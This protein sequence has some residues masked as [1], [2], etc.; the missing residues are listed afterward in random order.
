M[1][2]SISGTPTRDPAGRDR[3]AR[4]EHQEPFAR[5]SR[6]W[7]L[8]EALGYAG[9]FIDPTGVLASQRF[10]RAEEKEQRDGRQ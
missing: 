7:V 2:Q 10:R 8:L 9:A 3:E 1:S 6:L 4:D 5:P